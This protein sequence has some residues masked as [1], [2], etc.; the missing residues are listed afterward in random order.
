[1]EG[2][3]SIPWKDGSKKGGRE[4]HVWVRPRFRSQGSK[5]EVKTCEFR[6]GRPPRDVSAGNRMEVPAPQSSSD[7][8]LGSTDRTTVRPP[9]SIPPDPSVLVPRALGPTIGNAWDRRLCSW[10]EDAGV[11]FL[12]SPTLLHPP[13]TCPSRR[14]HARRSSRH[15]HVSMPSLSLCRGRKWGCPDTT[16]VT[17]VVPDLEDP[18]SRAYEPFQPWN[19]ARRGR[20][21]TCPRSPRR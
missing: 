11:P 10:M 2:T 12:P 20:Q 13:W 7:R 16:R 8:R 15:L 9:G 21:E 19:W 18:A 6:R 14:S 3:R 4:G 17:P 1:M 5:G